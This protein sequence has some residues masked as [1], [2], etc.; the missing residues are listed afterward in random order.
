MRSPPL[1]LLAMVVLPLLEIV[2]AAR[3]ASAFPAPVRSF[4]ISRSGSAFSARRSPRAT[5]SCSRSPPAPSF[6]QGRGGASADISPPRCACRSVVLAWG[7]VQMVATERD[8]G[9]TIGAGIPA[10][11]AQLVLPVAFAL[12]AAAPGLARR[13]DGA[14]GGCAASIGLVPALAADRVR[15]HVARGPA[16]LAVARLIVARAR[17]SARRCSRFSAAPRR[18]CSCTTASR[19][20]RF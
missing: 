5:A 20:R 9:T 2:F 19:R 18:A 7:G 16:G 1:A 6:R 8:A 11:V 4:S 15:R 13:R 17:R 14:P 10:W 3:S 12:I